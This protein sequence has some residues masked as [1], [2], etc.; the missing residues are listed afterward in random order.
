MRQLVFTGVAVLCLGSL[1]TAA[2]AQS[3][4]TVAAAPAAS[5]STAPAPASTAAAAAAS[6]PAASAAQADA[7]ANRIVC[8]SLPAPTGSRL[9][10]GRECHSQHDWDAMRQRAQDTVLQKQQWTASGGNPTN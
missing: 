10:G 7:D 6:V 3:A 1:S 9:G 4:E 2:W 5:S 8:R